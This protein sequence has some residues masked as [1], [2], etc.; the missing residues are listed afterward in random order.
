MGFLILLI[1]LVIAIPLPVFVVWL[2]RRKRVDYSC[3]SCAF[4][5]RHDL[6]Y[7]GEVA[8]QN[9]KVWRTS[10]TGARNSGLWESLGNP[11]ECGKYALKYKAK[12]NPLWGIL[13]GW[14]P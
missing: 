2:A 13:R 5:K 3:S 14:K 6:I 10:C 4:F 7:P 12:D 11:G 9:P 8:C 1:T